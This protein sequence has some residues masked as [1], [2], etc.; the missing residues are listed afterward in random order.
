MINKVF[1]KLGIFFLGLLSYLPFWFLYALSSLLYYPL[2]YL[3]GYR[4]K[5]VRK[6]LVSSFPEKSVE[7]IIAIE[8]EFYKHF[9][10]MIFENIKFN[11]ISKSEVLKRVEMIGCES[12]EEEYKKGKKILLGCSH[13]GNWELLSLAFAMYNPGKTLVIYKP[14]NNKSFDEWY[15]YWRTRLGAIFIPMRETLRAISAYKND[16]YTMCFASDQSP[17]KQEATHFI[18]FLNQPTAVLLGIEK[19]S[20]KTDNPVYYLNTERIGRGRYKVKLEPIFLNPT[21]TTDLEI[22]KKHFAIL[23]QTIKRAPSYWLWSHNRWKH[24]PDN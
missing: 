3:I 10:D 13:Y 6:N 15:K 8:K 4:R 1:S 20:R 23:E 2:Y 7:Q 17:V 24:K 5:V 21:E 16:N 14:L 11:S 9:T 19:V 18:E 22:T 12:F